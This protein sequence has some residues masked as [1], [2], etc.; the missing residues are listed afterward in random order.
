MKINKDHLTEI[1]SNIENK[2]TS[3]NARY[4]DTIADINNSKIR[5]DSLLEEIEYHKLKLYLIQTGEST[6]KENTK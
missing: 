6:V 3:L 2:L 1:V 5:A 4:E